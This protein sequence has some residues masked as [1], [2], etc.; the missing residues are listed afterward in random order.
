MSSSDVRDVLNLPE[1]SAGGSAAG[2]ARPAK[3]QKLSAPRPN[4]KGLAREVQNLGGDNPIAIVPEVTSFKKRRLANRK[5]AARWELQPFRNSARDDSTLLLRHWRRTGDDQQQQEQQQQQQQ[6][7]EQEQPQPPAGPLPNLEQTA[8]QQG[9]AGAEVKQEEQKTELKT[10]EADRIQDS[11]FAKFNVEVSI[12]RY[13][14][15][16]YRQTLTSDEWSKEETDYLLGLARDFDLRWPL[17]WDRYEWNP[18][19]TN[20]EANDDGDESKAIVPKTQNRTMEDLKARYYEVAAKM[21]AV[22]KPVQFMTQP[23]FSLHET[24]AHFNPQQEKARKDFAL[25]SLARSREEAREEESLLLEIKRILARSERFNEDRRELYNRLDYPHAETD[26]SNFKSSAGL[27]NLLQNLMTADKTKKRRSLMGPDAA[28]SPHPTAAQ[29][30]APDASRRDSTAASTGNAAPTPTGGSKKGQ[31]AQQP[32]ERPKLTEKEEQ[33]YGVT[34][35]ERLGSGPAFRTE[36]INKML[37][38]RSG[39]Q[40]QRINNALNELDVPSR[41]VMPTAASVMQYEQLLGAVNNLLDARK[42]SDKL[43]AETKLEQAKKTERERKL[44]KVPEDETESKETDVKGN[45]EEASNQEKASES[46]EQPSTKTG[47]DEEPQATVE[48]EKAA[49]EKPETGNDDNEDAPEGIEGE[50]KAEEEDSA[51]AQTESSNAP[52]KRSA[53]V[54]SAVSDKSA[55]RQKKQ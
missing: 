19:A 6:Q 38:Q 12:P 21:M 47:K 53:S 18:P 49:A 31:Q 7:Q 40:Q 5:P 52:H 11:A 48:D 25:N 3:K 30:Q 54:L 8:A 20:G 37:S 50:E 17:I 16:Q 15:D 13:T 51:A 33:I 46:T 42:L 34:H 39:Q 4:L 55:K 35:F 28:P 45:G 43:E 27:Q 44:G 1:G 24:M 26:I 10:S 2:G 22:Q 32:S 41:L 23:E 9:E 29:A 14:D 36:K